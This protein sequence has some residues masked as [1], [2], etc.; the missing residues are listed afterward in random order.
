MRVPLR[1][2][3][4]LFLLFLQQSTFAN[5]N[6]PTLEKAQ[7]MFHTAT[8]TTQYAAAARQ[9]EFLVDEEGLRNGHLFYTIGNCWFMADDIG[10]AILNYRRAESYLPHNDDLQNNL[11]IALQQ[12]VDFIPETSTAWGSKWYINAPPALC[13]TLFF[14]SWIGLWVALFFWKKTKRKELRN[15]FILMSIVSILLAGSLW[16][17]TIQHNKKQSGV[18]LDPEVFARKGDGEIY[19]YAFATPLHAG[20]EFKKIEDRGTWWEIQLVDGKTCWIPSHSAE[21]ISFNK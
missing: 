3:G 14:I 7:E 6:V 19:E 2:M 18:L 4:W 5:Y 21:E 1:W 15:L 16:Q 13:P 8:N 9:Y 12:R 20:T 11:Q 10:R 17:E